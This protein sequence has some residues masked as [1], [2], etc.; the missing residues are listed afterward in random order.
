MSY[1][2]SI[3]SK[4]KNKKLL[5]NAVLF[6][7]CFLVAALCVFSAFVPIESWKYRIRL[8]EVQPRAAGEL[9]AHYLDVGD[10]ACCV[11]E[12][13][14]GKNVVV[15]GGM[16][17]GL[18]RKNV[19]RFLNALKIEEID[20]LIVTD[21]S[22]HG[23]G[24]LRE[25]VRYYDVKSV[26]LPANDRGNATYSAFLA[27]VSRHKIPAYDT[28]FG[29]LYDREYEFTIL[30]PLENEQSYGGTALL[31][32]YGGYHLLLG[33]KCT[34][35]LCEA[36]INEKTLGLLGR[37]GVE[38]DTLDVVCFDEDIDAEVLSRFLLT[39][40]PEKIL[41][42]CQGGKGY[43]PSWECIDLLAEAE[44]EVYRTD[45]NGR[46]TVSITSN[47]CIAKAEK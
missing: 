15:G 17:D 13:P 4:R 8:P 12:L 1:R 36:L 20:A 35:E 41:F 11:V 45:K 46:I 25:I 28:L 2:A 30:Y 14:D 26:Y 32:S 44:A 10:G 16:D 19:L 33:E 7:V 21:S 23:V 40:Y 31:L 27:D 37:W 22:Y 43:Q 3:R 34:E 6:G 47:A 5:R 29:S 39:F 42:S 38:L 24:A 9:R 18:A